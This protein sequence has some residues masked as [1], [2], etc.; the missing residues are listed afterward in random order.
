MRGETFLQKSFS[1]RPSSKNSYM[2]SGGANADVGATGEAPFSF[3][4]F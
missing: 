2:A 1:P 4:L 3:P